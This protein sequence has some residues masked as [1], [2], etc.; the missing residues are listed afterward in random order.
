[1]KNN[2][3]PMVAVRFAEWLRL[4]FQNCPEEMDNLWEDVHYTVDNIS[5]KRYTTIELW[6][7]WTTNACTIWDTGG[8]PLVEKSPYTKDDMKDIS[9]EMDKNIQDMADMQEQLRNM[10]LNALS[11]SCTQD[12][13]CPN[14][15][16]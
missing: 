3:T 11:C 2:D 10:A 4:N 7:Y 1:M 8:R 14:C 16:P 13:S 15:H 5:I 9:T 12:Q 6:K